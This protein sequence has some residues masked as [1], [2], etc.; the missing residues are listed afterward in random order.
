MQPT[1]NLLFRNLTRKSFKILVAVYDFP[2]GKNLIYRHLVVSKQ[3]FDM[4]CSYPLRKEGWGQKVMLHF[5]G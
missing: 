5:N 4:T 2:P 1:T 3:I